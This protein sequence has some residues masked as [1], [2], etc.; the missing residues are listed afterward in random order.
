MHF[1]AIPKKKKVKVYK[2]PMIMKDG[3]TK[4]ISFFEERI[5]WLWFS[6]KYRW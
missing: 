3:G 4:I 1:H 6:I 5:C 2:E